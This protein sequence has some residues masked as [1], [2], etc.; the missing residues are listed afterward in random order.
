MKSSESLLPSCHPW[1]LEFAQLYFELSTQSD[2]FLE[3]TAAA[4][5]LMVKFPRLHIILNLC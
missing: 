5:L 2:Q 4:R 1:G 3:V